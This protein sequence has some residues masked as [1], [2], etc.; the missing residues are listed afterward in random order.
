MRRAVV[1]LPFC[2][3]AFAL[4]GYAACS[5]DLDESLLAHDAGVTDVSVEGAAGAPSDAPS[6]T[7]SDTSSCRSDA[8]CGN[9]GCL[10]GRCVNGECTFAICPS[11]DPCEARACEGGSNRC[12]TPAPVAFR[13]GGVTLDQGIGCNGNPTACLAAMGDYALVGTADG[14]LLAF[15]VTNPSAPEEVTVEA[16]PFAITRLISTA[17]RVLVVGPIAG[18]KLSLAW[19]DLPI[20]ARAEMLSSQSIAVTFSSVFHEA[21]A[22]EAGAFFLVKEEP[23]EFFPA[24]HL[25]PPL[26]ANQTVSLL[27]SSGIPAGESMVGASG[28]RLVAFRVDPSS[29]SWAPQFSLETNAGTSAAQNTGEQSVL[30]EAGEVPQA[31]KTHFF[32][33]GSDGSLLW[34]TNRIVRPDG[35]AGSDAVVFRWPLVGSETTFSGARQVVVES[36]PTQ[37]ADAILGGPSALV[38]PS[39][40][41]V[42]AADPAN[43][44]QTSV[45][46]VTR[47][48]DILTLKASRHVLPFTTTAIGVAAGSRFAYVL[49][50]STRAPPEAPDAAL[51]VFAPLCGD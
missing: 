15:R 19:I 6:D 45:R 1:W 10:E 9:D 50:P 32:A 22:A 42:T 29:G 2:V 12:G 38:A 21:Y 5:L 37:P 7:P 8:D 16:P 48:A 51:H 13:A 46:A 3:G 30:E 34:T 31:D 49:T 26:A 44:V 24:A 20:D 25:K 40:A 23:A 47:Q 17:N 41:L 35:G 14:G 33:C 39:T 36:Y 11:D 43:M 27:P 4:A 28:T 18:G